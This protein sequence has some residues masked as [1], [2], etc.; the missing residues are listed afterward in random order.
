MCHKWFT[1]CCTDGVDYN[2]NLSLSDKT[3][4]ADFKPNAS[5]YLETE[6]DYDNPVFA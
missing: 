2:F 5:P 3:M 1:G 6:T 4:S